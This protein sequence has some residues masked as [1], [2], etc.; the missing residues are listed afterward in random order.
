MEKLSAQENV[1][2]L[3]FDFPTTSFYLREIARKLDLS[4]SVVSNSL[5]Q[6]SSKNLILL[7]KKRFIYEAK[8]NLENE[9]FKLYKR[10]Y[11]LEKIYFSGLFDYLLDNF[12]LDTIVL[13]GSYSRGED[14]EKSD[15]DIAIFSNFKK[16]DLAKFEKLLNRSINIEF[17]DFK[18]AETSLKTSLINGIVLRGSIQYG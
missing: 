12:G 5:N 8:A 6:L 18:K 16:L 10:V 7:S 3:F 13:F 4:T 14:S 1:L 17:I 9:K 2:S 15:V 11:N